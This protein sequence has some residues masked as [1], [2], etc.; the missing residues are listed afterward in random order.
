MLRRRGLAA[1]GRC[2]DPEEVLSAVQLEGIDPV[3]QQHPEFADDD[4][5]RANPGRLAGLA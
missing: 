4:F 2:L 5:V 1:T 3:C